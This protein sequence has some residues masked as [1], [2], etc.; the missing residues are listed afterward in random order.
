MTNE[1]II[2]TTNGGQKDNRK[3]N[4]IRPNK[5][6]QYAGIYLLQY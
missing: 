6:Q 4:L 2:V 3:Y 5:M 1:N